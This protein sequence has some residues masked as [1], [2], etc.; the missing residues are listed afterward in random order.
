M[1]FTLAHPAAV[2]PLHRL[3]LPVAAVVAGSMVPDLP[4][5]VPSPIGYGGTHSLIGLVTVDMVVGV[6]AVAAWF[7]VL[8]DP[9]VDCAPA[10][11][12]RRLPARVRY[13]RRQCLLTPVGVVVG[14]ATHVLWDGFTHPGRWG[15][16]HIGWLGEQHGLWRGHEWAQYVS[17][18]GGL[19][20]VGAWACLAVWRS[21]ADH[22]PVGRPRL[23]PVALLV[24][25]LFTAVCTAGAATGHFPRGLH[26]MAYSGAVAGVVALSAGIAALAVLW[27]LRSHGP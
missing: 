9:L 27:H 21:S 25:L 24:L 12:R 1:P 20:V 4:L 3:G 2:L 8:R 5:F 19:L 16:R 13:S 26:A 22:A 18:V 7:L 23:G 17:G 15:V 11:V 6:V 10:L 14:A